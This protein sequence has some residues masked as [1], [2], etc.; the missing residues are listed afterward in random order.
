[1]ATDS[2]TEAESDALDSDDAPGADAHLR[3]ALVGCAIASGFGLARVI[4]ASADGK[5][6][7]LLVLGMAVAGAWMAFTRPSLI[8]AILIAYLP[9]SQAYP[10]PIFGLPG[11]NGSNLALTLGI[12]AWVA[13]AL[14]R[15][16]R[17][18]GILGVLVVAYLVLGALGAVTGQ[19]RLGGIDVGDLLTDYRWWA[20][21]IVLFFIA[22]GTMEDGDDANAF[23]ANLAY[24]TFVIGALTWMDGIE[25]RDRRAIED[26]RVPG[27]LGQP[28]TMGAFLAYYGAPLLALAVAK[29][30]WVSRALCLAA[31]LVVARSIIF[32]FSRGALLSLLAGSAAVVGMVNP[33]GVGVVGAAGLVARSNPQVLPGSVRDRFAQT[34]DEDT[35]IYAESVEG[36][37]DKSSAERLNLWRGG[38]AMM[39]AHPIG[40][41]GLKRFQGIVV[42]Y[43]PEPVDPEGAKDAHNAYIL[44]GAE[45]GLPALFVMLAILV[46]IG[47]AA[48]GS[49]WRGPDL[50]E[51]R[52]ALA[53]L[54]CVA[55]VMV[56]CVFGSRF[57][58]DA[59]IGPF[60]LLAGALSALRTRPDD[61]D[62]EDPASLDG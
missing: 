49:W 41:V 24:V 48:L 23:L 9:F 42:V 45:L 53:C 7:S 22:R 19:L 4:E 14:S 16:R 52:L 5:L 2:I 57:S 20:A 55:A 50:A 17:A 56:S 21:P 18:L 46:G 6:V 28:N 34:A 13:S 35:D 3:A 38:L 10:S 37:L 1:M 12:A 54:G 29:G 44:T 26:Q 58:E 59:L 40:G 60:W 15:E 36:Q 47:F 62:E 11:L 39:R 32:T 51:R 33:V 25:F 27:V 30:R 43:A 31:F 61:D 8:S